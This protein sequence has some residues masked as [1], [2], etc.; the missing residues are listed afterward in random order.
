MEDR[1]SELVLPQLA[2]MLDSL[3]LA[4]YGR[5]SRMLHANQATGL[6]PVYL[7]FGVVP[8]LARRSSQSMSPTA[9]RR[10]IGFV[11]LLATTAENPTALCD[12]GNDGL[13]FHWLRFEGW[14]CWRIV[15]SSRNV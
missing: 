3:A 5:S 8:A 10:A 12:F 13:V 11:L 7:S 9:Y 6:P 1:F 15:V 14:H 4:A 2:F